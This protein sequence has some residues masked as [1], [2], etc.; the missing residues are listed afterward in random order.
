MVACGVNSNFRGNGVVL[1][2][3]Q[4]TSLG[5]Q[6][7][8]ENTVMVERDTFVPQAPEDKRLNN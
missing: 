3:S 7:Y 6:S 2:E 5:S 1:F 4:I 8:V